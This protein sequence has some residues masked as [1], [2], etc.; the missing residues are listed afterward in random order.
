ML[1]R[2]SDTLFLFLREGEKGIKEVSRGV[3]WQNRRLKKSTAAFDELLGDLVGVRLPPKGPKGEAQL[4]GHQ[5]D[6]ATLLPVMLGKVAAELNEDAWI[7]HVTASAACTACSSSKGQEWA[8][9]DAGMTLMKGI[10][11]FCR[12]PW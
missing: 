9:R 5:S 10:K 3:S 1:E 11:Q 8:R 7:H 4:L 2:Q 12:L 6:P